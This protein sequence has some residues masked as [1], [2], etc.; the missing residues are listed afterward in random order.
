M[1]TVVEDIFEECGYSDIAKTIGENKDLRRNFVSVLDDMYL[2]GTKEQ[3]LKFASK[4]WDLAD[5]VYND[6]AEK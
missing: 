6:V 4:F 2:K 3:F 5:A 1:K